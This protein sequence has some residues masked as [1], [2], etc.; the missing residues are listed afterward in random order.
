MSSSNRDKIIP[1]VSYENSYTLKINILAE[2]KNK[3]G[4]YMW[5]NNITNKSY[6]GSAVNLSNRFKN[7]YNRSY[8]IKERKSNNSRIYLALLIY[9]HSFFK[10]DII[11][12]CEPSVLISREQYYLDLLKPEYNILKTAG[13][14]L[15][16][17][18]SKDIK[19]KIRNSKLGS[20][21]IEAVKLAIA[22]GNP[23]SQRIKVTD[24]VTGESKEYVSIRRA[25]KHIGLH[26]SYLAK[27]IKNNLGENYFIVRK[28]IIHIVTQ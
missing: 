5:T 28:K 10:L 16:F 27:V 4:I 12:Y 24:I 7:Y 9:Q 1:L 13:S 23:K 20:N 18:H 26:H 17:K 14:I 25:A 15:G 2:N 19:E 3:S 22:L 6:V 8:L 11:E 21:R